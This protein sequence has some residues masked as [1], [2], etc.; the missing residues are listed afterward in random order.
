MK[1]KEQSAQPS[2]SSTLAKYQ[3]K[4]K[5]AVARPNRFETEKINFASM[6]G[7]VTY[8]DDEAKSKNKDG[9]LS[10]EIVDSQ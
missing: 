3:K 4:E 7:E 6:I 2:P 10:Y 9:E 1:D 5:K 8:I